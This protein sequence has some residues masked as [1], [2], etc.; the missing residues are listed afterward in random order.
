MNSDTG[1]NERFK[2]V[3][4]LLNMSQEEFGRA[5]GLSKSAISNIEKGVR[6]LRD[7]YISTICST[8]NINAYWLRT[9]KGEI[10]LA[11]SVSSYEAFEGY[12]KS[13][14]YTVQIFTSSDG[15]NSLLELSKDGNRIIY[16]DSEFED[17]ENSIKESI[18]YQ[19]WKKQQK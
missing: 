4:L 17:F 10:L 16:T 5:I 6:G 13:I 14:G 3:R 19:I 12:L 1:I 18:E 2:Q 8:F 7:A 11:D 9:G 15:E